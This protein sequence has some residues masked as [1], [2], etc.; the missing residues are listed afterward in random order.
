MST[1]SSF[2]TPAVMALIL[3]IPV[4]F[5]T[6]VGGFLKYALGVWA[7]RTSK[8]PAERKAQAEVAGRAVSSSPLKGLIKWPGAK[9]GDD[10]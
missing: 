3:A 2:L 1:D 8:S 6:A 7:I 4:A 9:E 10:P 5:L